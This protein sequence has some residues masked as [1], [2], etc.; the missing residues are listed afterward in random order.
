MSLKAVK[1]LATLRVGV[2]SGLQAALV[3]RRAPVPAVWCSVVVSISKIIHTTCITY[4]SMHKQHHV[5]RVDPST[6]SLRMH[7][8]YVTAHVYISQILQRL[9]TYFTASINIASISVMSGGQMCCAC[10]NYMCSH[11]RS[12]RRSAHFPLNKAVHTNHCNRAA[13]VRQPSWW[14]WPLSFVQPSLCI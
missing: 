3:I 2:F 8:L 11:S 10:V 12:I 9:I 14:M 7:R 6:Y 13:T 1:A 5:I 4:L